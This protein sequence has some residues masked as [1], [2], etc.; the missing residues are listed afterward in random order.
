MELEIIFVNYATKKCTRYH[1]FQFKITDGGCLEK[2]VTKYEIIKTFI[3]YELI[4]EKPFCG[5]KRIT[6][7]KEPS[8]CPCCSF[9]KRKTSFLNS[10]SPSF[11]TCETLFKTIIGHRKA[12]PLKFQAES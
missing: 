7:N 10:C 6:K 8:K 1:P 5:S 2:E 3:R 9:V 4:Y 12:Y 11:E